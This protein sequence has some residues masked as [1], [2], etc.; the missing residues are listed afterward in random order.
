MVVQMEY[1]P[2]RVMEKAGAM[3]GMTSPRV[4]KDLERFKEFIEPGRRFEA[5]L[6]AIRTTRR[7]GQGKDLAVLPRYE[8]SHEL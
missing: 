5:P 8:H 6:K 1:K 2:Q 4:E 7:S 3:V